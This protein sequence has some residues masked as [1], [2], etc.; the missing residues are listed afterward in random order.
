M[1]SIED[2]QPDW[3]QPDNRKTKISWLMDA[4]LLGIED[5]FGY[6]DI[7]LPTLR[8]KTLGGTVHD[9]EQVT[10][11]LTQAYIG[12]PGDQASGPMPCNGPRTGIFQIQVVRCFKDG[13]SKNIRAGN[14]TAP[15]PVVIGEYASQ[16]AEDLWALLDVPGFVPDYNFAIGDVSVTDPEGGYQAAQ[17]TLIIQI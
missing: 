6:Y 7:E 5:A 1:P 2:P 11:S 13:S 16:R 9:C 15:D 4:I 10:V 8:Y 14:S 17:M 12:P 3:E